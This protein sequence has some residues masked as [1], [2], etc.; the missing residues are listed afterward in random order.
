MLLI[1]AVGL[2]FLQLTALLDVD[3]SLRLGT[4][5]LEPRLRV[6]APGITVLF[7]P[8]GSGKTSLINAIAG[9]LTPAAGHVEVLGERFFD[10]ARNINVPVEHRHLGY[11]FQDGR[12]FPHLNVAANL[13]YGQRRRNRPQDKALALRERDNVVALLG[14]GDLLERRPIHLSGGERQRVAFGRAI[15]SSPRLLLLDEPLSSLDAARK[16]EIVPYLLAL[17]DRLQLPMLLVTHNVDE[18]LRLA[19]N[20]VLLRSGSVVGCGAVADVL[21][22]PAAL[23]NGFAQGTLIDA[24][25]VACRNDLAELDLGGAALLMPR[26]PRTNNIRAG[27]RLRLWI[28]ADSVMLSASTEFTATRA[29]PLHI[30]VE[31]IMRQP[32]DLV[33]VRGRAGNA[34]IVAELPGTA[35]AQLGITPGSACFAHLHPVVLG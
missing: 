3:V 34:I 19:D 1:D 11:V 8:S 33:L 5:V 10:H 13:A 18:V 12:L 7:G 17:R 30:I 20:L 16:A 32:N 9:L 26:L 14:L 31:T 6:D 15:L 2:L 29:A 24:L 4:T 28:P 27:S 25:Y 22:Q 35:I 23:A 21:L